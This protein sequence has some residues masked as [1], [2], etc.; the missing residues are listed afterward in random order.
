MRRPDWA[1][2]WGYNTM[3]E[4]QAKYQTGA[5]K[6][7]KAELKNT[8]TKIW[9]KAKGIEIK[10]ALDEATKAELRKMLDKAVDCLSAGHCPPD[11]DE[12]IE[13]G[14]EVISCHICWMD[15]LLDERRERRD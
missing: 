10:K 11:M 2:Q 15:F 1:A 14:C 3:S 5:E 9:H 4:E 6:M 13:Y 12:D 7:T 8:L